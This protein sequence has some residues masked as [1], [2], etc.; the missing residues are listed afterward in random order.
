MKLRK[1][2]NRLAAASSLGAAALAVALVGLAGPASA[3]ITV[4]PF[5]AASSSSTVVAPGVTQQFGAYPNWLPANQSV[6]NVD[7]SEGSDTTL[8]MMEGISN[9]Y[10]QAGI[11]PFSCTLDASDNSTCS[12]TNA[13]QTQT[14]LT[15]NYASTEELQG[16]NYVGSSNGIKELCGTYTFP[17]TTNVDYSRSSKPPGV[18]TTCS[19]GTIGEVG[20]AKDAVIPMDFQTI[21]PAAY[22]SSGDEA[23]GYVGT[24]FMSYCPTST[25]TNSTTGSSPSV[26]SSVGG[27]VTTPF[28]STGIGDVAAGWEPGNSFTCTP[29][30]N[31]AL[32]GTGNFCSGTPFTNLTN[33]EDPSSTNGTATSVAYRLF[34]QHGSSTTPYES[35]IMDWG[36]LTNLSAAANGGTAAKPG[37]GAPIGVPIRIIGVNTGSGTLSTFYSFTQSG[38]T[39]GTNCTGAAPLGSSSNVDADAASGQN[40]QTSQGTSGNLEIAVEN[41]VNQVGDFASANWADNSG[42]TSATNADAADQAVDIATSLYFESLGV[43]STNPNAQV[44]S[45][46]IPS[47]ATAGLIPSGQPSTFLAGQMSANGTKILVGSETTNVYA[48]DRTLFNAYN[49]NSLKASVG[50]FLNWMC[51]ANSDF[52]KG[53]DR[54]AGGNYDT[55]LTNLI[56]GQFGFSRLS[57]ITPELAAN[58]QTTTGDNIGDQRNG[59]CAANLAVASTG[60]SG[61]NT[62]TLTAAP[63]APVQVGWPV[64]VP[65]GYGVAIPANT[66][67]LGISNSPTPGVISLGTTTGAPSTTV[68][69]AS[70]GGTPASVA[71]WSTPANGDLAVASVSGLPTSGV[72]QVA[73]SGG[74]AYVA[75]TGLDTGHNYLTGV[76]FLSQATPGAATTVSTGGTVTVVQAS[77]LTGGSGSGTPAYLYFP[78]HPPILSVTSPNT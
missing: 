37:D 72:V 68:A 77:N 13:N 5:P 22:M 70:N 19:S 21:D 39:G 44:T 61:S 15:D 33:T 6:S 71:S 34:C 23:P 7:H 20:Y 64:S 29:T 3:A 35:Q 27:T 1:L 66:V 9:L 4:P 26:C 16:I 56:Q 28:P 36:N 40:P 67:V 57:D 55:D 50:G 11:N 41:D 18:G 65:A 43:Y 59:T 32:Q 47:N 51:D 2:R 54:I 38:I 78:D 49:T 14:D 60:G 46:E 52:Q 58:L 73:T 48:M 53:V 10:A 63:P 8:F 42:V 45:I 69:S 24:T 74:N 12:S 76:T 17:G 75:Y 62:V 31:P 30:A 25:A